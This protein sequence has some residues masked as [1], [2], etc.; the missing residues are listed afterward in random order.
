[1]PEGFFLC[2]SLRDF[3]NGHEHIIEVD[4]IIPKSKSG[5]D[6]YE[7]LQLIHRHCHDSKTLVDIHNEATLTK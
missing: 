1:M 6:I 2:K 7:N 5:K 4:H 3:I